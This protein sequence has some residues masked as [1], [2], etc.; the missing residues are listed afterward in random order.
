M[1]TTPQTCKELG[2]SRDT[3]RK[4]V[5]D[6]RIAAIRIGAW[7]GGHLRFSEQAIEDYKRQQAVGAAESDAS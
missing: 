6:K 2:I 4:L 7:P 5:K 1:L 3:L